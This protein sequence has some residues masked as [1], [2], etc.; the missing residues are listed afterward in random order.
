VI[1]GRRKPIV[2]L[3]GT[4]WARRWGDWQSGSALVSMAGLRH[5]QGI[6]PNRAADFRGPP[7][8]LSFCHSLQC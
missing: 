5:V 6:R 8:Q 3:I 1:T 7:F 2:Y 4:A